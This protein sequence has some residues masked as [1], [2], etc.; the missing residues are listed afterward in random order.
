M[1]VV[2]IV[3]MVGKQSK[4]VWWKTGGQGDHDYYNREVG[5][6]SH[7]HKQMDIWFDLFTNRDRSWKIPRNCWLLKSL[8]A[9]NESAYQ[10]MG[11]DKL[12]SMRLHGCKW[13]PAAHAIAQ[14]FYVCVVWLGMLEC[15]RSIVSNGG[16]RSIV[17]LTITASHVDRCLHVT[18][19]L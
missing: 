6:T 17:Q 13:E 4:G 5:I 19:V 14:L 8:W 16:D 3:T 11:I 2:C 15:V 18:I 12:C 9:H 10:R 7:A 1:T